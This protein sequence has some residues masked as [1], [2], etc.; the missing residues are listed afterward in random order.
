LSTACQ[1]L[2]WVARPVPPVISEQAEA[3]QALRSPVSW[4]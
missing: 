3:V 4:H 2:P 1:R